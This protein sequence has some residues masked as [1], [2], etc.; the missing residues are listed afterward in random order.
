MKTVKRKRK[1]RKI[2]ALVPRKDFE[3]PAIVRNDS[4]DVAVQLC[5]VRM[6]T[7]VTAHYEAKDCGQDADLPVLDGST[8]SFP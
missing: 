8:R 6:G 5:E 2:R 4:Y 3:F 1:Q 7:S